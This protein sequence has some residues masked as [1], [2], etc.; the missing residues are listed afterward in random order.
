MEFL[1]KCLCSWNINSSMPISFFPPKLFRSYIAVKPDFF[2]SSDIIDKSCHNL[3]FLIILELF[4][5]LNEQKTKSARFPIKMAA[6]EKMQEN[7][8]ALKFNFT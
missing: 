5:L 7:K 4:F 3:I 1:M 8:L 2:M 6:N